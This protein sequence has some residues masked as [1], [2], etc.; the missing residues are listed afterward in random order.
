MDPSADTI[1]AGATPPGTGGIGIVRLSGPDVPRLARQLL[2]SL[3]EPRHATWRMFRDAAGDAV[4]SGIALYY[5]A[6]ASFTGEHVLELQGHGG[7]VVVGLVVDAAVAL[8]ARPARAGEFSERAFLNGK[9]D[10]AQAEA[11]ADL[12]ESH[13]AQAVRA[14]LRSLSGEFSAAV[15]ELVEQLTRLRIHVEAAIDFPDEDVDFLADAALARRVDEAGAALARLRARAGH[16]R[17]LRDGFE[18]AIV[19]RPN[20]GKSSLMNRLAGSDTAIV[21]E[22]AGTTRDVLRETVDM[23]GLAVL[24]VD[25][26]GLRDDADRVEAEGIRRARQ[27]IERADCVLW[28]T[29]AG[30]GDTAPAEP[31]PDAATLLRVINKIDLSGESPGAG[32]DGAI[33]ISAKTG[34]GIDA[35]QS[36]L[37]ELAGYA[38]PGAGALS[39]RRRHLEALD[40]AAAHFEAGRRAL[41]G[42]AAGEIM[43]EELRLAQAVLGEITGAVSADDLLGRIF[44]EFC[45]GK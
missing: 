36:R 20:A 12:I 35:L 34:A 14:A 40:R 42:S 3:P 32:D 29:D 16:G 2:G 15:H 4:D 33:R 21:T 22:V 8:G 24:L 41:A 37:V 5:P 18:V 11:V 23:D 45:I 27:A 28:L 17:L 39:A 31:I 10:L 6:P 44:G 26:A 7:P 38:D 1:V 30:E 13:T 43:A 19:G 25:T 9:L